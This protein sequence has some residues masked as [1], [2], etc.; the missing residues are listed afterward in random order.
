MT[1]KDWGDLQFEL[2]LE[3]K[4]TFYFGE[5]ARTD[6]E[7][8]KIRKRERDIQ[9]AVRA[10]RKAYEEDPTR[11]REALKKRT[12]QLI[13]GNPILILVAQ[14]LLSVAIKYAVEW[15]LDRIYNRQETQNDAVSVSSK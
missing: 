1:S 9:T 7:K 2:C 11:S 12:Y 13:T 15:L 3:Q 14:V 5:T 10:V 8:R 4:C 6:K